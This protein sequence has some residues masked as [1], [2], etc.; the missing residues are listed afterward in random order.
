LVNR[1]EWE[2]KGQRVVKEMANSIKAIESIQSIAFNIQRIRTD[3]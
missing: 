3:K 2:I 1:K